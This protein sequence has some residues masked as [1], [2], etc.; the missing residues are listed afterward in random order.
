M[1]STTQ[2]TLM[3]F[4]VA[5]LLVG[6]AAMGIGSRVAAGSAIEPRRTQSRPRVV[7]GWPEGG[8]L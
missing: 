4:R 7:A 8:G 5:G 6:M 3:V 1:N 2:T